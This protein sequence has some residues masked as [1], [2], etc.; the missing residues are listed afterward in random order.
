MKLK[1]SIYYPLSF[2]VFLAVFYILS[3]ASIG[4]VLYPFAI[5]FMFAL[6]WV[7]QKPWVVCPAFLAGSILFDYGFTNI[8]CSIC[9]VFM[10]VVPYYIHIIMRKNIKI[11][12]FGIYC[13]IAYLPKILFSLSY[14]GQYYYDIISLVCGILFFLVAIQILETLFI[15]GIARKLNVLEYASGGIILAVLSDGLTF[16]T[17]GPF[18]F[19]KLFVAFAILFIAY[20]SKSYYAVFISAILGVGSLL[21]MNNPVYIAPFIIWAMFISPFKSYKKYFMPVAILL[22]E[23]L[24]GF[25]FNLYYSFSVWKI[26][27]VI[28]ACLAFMLIPEKFYDKIRVIL[29]IKPSR[30]A[31]KDVVNR[32]REVLE[33]RLSC[34]SDVFSDMER[35]FRKLAKNS[36]SKKD[37]T[38]VLKRETRSKVCENCPNFNRCQRSYINEMDVSFNE[39]SEIAFEKG[40]INI[41]DLPSF[42]TSH[43]TKTTAI[44][45]S[46]NT[47]CE[48]YKRYSKLVGSVDMSKLLIADEFCGI[49]NVFK[50]L[51]KEIEAPISFDCA[52]EEKI[53]QELLFNDVICDDIAV[54]EKDIHSL[55]VTVLVRNE[56]QEKTLIPKVIGK[57][58]G[59]EMVI[60]EKI[61]SLKPGWTVLLLK[62]APKYDCLF[63]I[64]SKSKGNSLKS[65]DCHSVVKLSSDKFMFALC[66]GMGSGEK[67]EE[68]SSVAIEM[69]ENFYKAGFNGDLI[70]S[71][72]NKLLSLQQQDVFSAVDLCVLDLNIGI[73]NFIKMGSP[74]CFLVR[75][76]DCKIIEGGSLPVG[77]ISD[78]TPSE[79]KE[80]V[81]SGDFVVLVSDGVSDS[82]ESDNALGEYI[83]SLNDKNPQSFSDKILEKALSN[84]GQIA[85][86]DMT[87]LVIKII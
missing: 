32:N 26:S 64:S 46:I 56:D 10:V 31:V 45:S 63:G 14:N 84:S 80:I 34:L 68:I 61:S 43:C 78:E 53:V 8:I 75:K 11:W 42:L 40:K 86:D 6:V 35:N 18:S 77:I 67:A 13:A 33:K 76:D 28:M 37:I 52:K 82:F 50:N 48:Q 79:K 19:L 27:P 22:A 85:K 49:S 17:V 41:L 65:G 87:V 57:I 39:I 38:D 62:N 60:Q 36:L 71:S 7:N 69:I 72:V 59:I 3:N 20:S 73:A 66:D 1:R 23:C 12:E 55:E 44:I 15:R 21:G 5:G 30:I 2:V 74:A 25:Y 47:V 4:A 24:I 29:R 81:D 83:C 58:C 70:M 54:F 16:L 9:A 51:S